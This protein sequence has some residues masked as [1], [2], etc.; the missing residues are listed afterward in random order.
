MITELNEIPLFS[1]LGKNFCNELKKEIYTKK[2][3]KNSIVFYEGDKSEY[4]Y[5]LLKGVVRLY[6]TSPRGSQVQIH[7]FTAPNIIG[8]YIC[9]QKKPFPVTCEFITDGMIGLLHFKK[10]YKYLDNKAFS[11]ELISALTDKIVLLSS[12][13]RQETIFTAEAKIADFILTKIDIF[14]KLKQIEIAMILNLTPETF[15]RILTKFKQE[16]IILIK[17]GKL[18]VTN[19]EILKMIIETNSIRSCLQCLKKCEKNQKVV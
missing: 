9:F 19:R 11:L 18:K 7:R 15:S 14:N 10:I 4:V 16:N 8:E 2:F 3:N 6:M 12:L 1:K 17:N 5:I 13:I